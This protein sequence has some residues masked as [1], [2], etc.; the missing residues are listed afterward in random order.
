MAGMTV[1]VRIGAFVVAVALCGV[2]V[3]E[4]RVGRPQCSV[5]VD[6]VSGII[7]RVAADVDLAVRIRVV[8]ICIFTPSFINLNT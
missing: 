2:V 1:V 7:V 5:V 3:V 4:V 6:V 8:V